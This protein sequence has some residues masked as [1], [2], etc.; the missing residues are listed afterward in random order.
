[1]PKRLKPMEL[2]ATQGY[3]VDNELAKPDMGYIEA[4]SPTKKPPIPESRPL[5]ED[6]ERAVPLSALNQVDVNMIPPPGMQAM[7]M[8][9][10]WG[11]AGLRPPFLANP[12][13]NMSVPFVQPQPQFFIQPQAFYDTQQHQ[14]TQDFNNNGMGMGM[15]MAPVPYTGLPTLPGPTDHSMVP[16]GAQHQQMVPHQALA[17]DGFNVAHP[18][19]PHDAFA[20]QN[21]QQPN[22]GATFSSLYNQ[23]QPIAQQQEFDFNN[24]ATANPNGV[25]NVVYLTD[26]MESDANNFNSFPVQQHQPT[27]HFLPPLNHQAA[28]VSMVFTDQNP[29]FT[30]T[31]PATA[32][33][34]PTNGQ[35]VIIISSGENQIPSTKFAN[36]A[37]G[38][39][40]Q[41][42]Y[43]GGLSA[44]GPRT[45]QP[46]NGGFMLEDEDALMV[47]HSDHPLVKM[48]KARAGSSS[49]QPWMIRSKNLS[50]FESGLQRQLEKK[51][52]K[53]P[54]DAHGNLLPPVVPSDETL[55]VLG[56]LNEFRTDRFRPSAP[57][58]PPPPLPPGAPEDEPGFWEREAQRIGS[59]GGSTVP[60][61]PEVNPRKGNVVVGSGRAAIKK[62]R[63][64]SGKGEAGN[65]AEMLATK[66]NWQL[67]EERDDFNHVSVSARGS[68]SYSFLANRAAEMDS[69]K[70]M[71][72]DK[73]TSDM[74]AKHQQ[75]YKDSQRPTSSDS[76]PIYASS[77]PGTATAP[78][79]H[80]SAATPPAAPPL[81]D[82]AVDE[83]VPI[84]M[85]SRT[86]TPLETSF[87]SH[88]QPAVGAAHSEATGTSGTTTESTNWKL[89]K[90]K[91]GK[92]K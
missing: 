13:L 69:K 33:V 47:S 65:L 49:K 78:S 35:S 40:Q 5:S 20:A 31:A 66:A 29:T 1:M 28:N 81:G 87:A 43:R 25:P 84:Y 55:E 63:L 56:M 54:R 7:P 6:G 46:S 83:D 11:M 18:V 9:L 30:T 79:Q 50:T 71:Q 8:M 57:P 70:V 62:L 12:F 74:V 21:V 72:Y 38:G 45:T 44:N 68:P 34:L 85:A 82:G 73:M 39:L 3:S 61:L 17:G 2:L 48:E 24:G 59:A 19:A 86:G 60:S 88:K 36:T 80:K 91:G 67:Q 32:T 4:T 53:F 37:P 27:R 64:G 15:G 89:K 16:P 42:G 22:M 26:L 51:L 23:L 41:T 90:L 14:P 92:R 77:K 52:S 58:E 76:N 10:P 75:R